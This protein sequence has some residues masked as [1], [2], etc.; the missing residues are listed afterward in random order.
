MPSEV[1]IITGE[2]TP[3]QYLM[4]PLLNAFNRAWRDS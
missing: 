2:S 4:D 3:A 1:M